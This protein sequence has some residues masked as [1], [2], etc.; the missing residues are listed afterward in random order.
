MGFVDARRGR[1]PDIATRARLT[2]FLYAALVVAL[3]ACGSGSPAA[4]SASARPTV[5]GVW[6]VSFTE[7]IM[8]LTLNE[9]SV[10]LTGTLESPGEFGS[11]RMSGTISPSGQMTLNGASASDGT[12]VSLQASVDAARQSFTGVLRLAAQGVSASFEIRGTKRSGSSASPPPA[13]PVGEVE[14]LSESVPFG[15]TIPTVRLGTSGQAAPTLTFSFAV[16]MFESQSDILAQVWVRTDAARCMGAGFAALTFAAGE[17]KVFNSA[18]VS[19]Q[20]GSDPA[21]CQLPYTTSFVEIT[22]VRQEQVILS[23]LFPGS[24]YFIASP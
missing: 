8:V 16:R 18:N 14:L 24:Y 6:D 11:I 13:S 19:F 21:P 2:R 4:P 7:G 22:L 15:Q 3:A 1:S 20:Q 12:Q 23:R 10:S 17:R 5:T 9:A